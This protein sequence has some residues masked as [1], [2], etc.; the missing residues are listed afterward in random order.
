MQKVTAY[1]PC[2][3]WREYKAS[4]SKQL[5]AG[6]DVT[7]FSSEFGLTPSLRTRVNMAEVSAIPDFSENRQRMQQCCVH[8]LRALCTLVR[9]D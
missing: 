3:T 6:R 9:P 8:A 4:G 1:S 5:G 7:R 2:F